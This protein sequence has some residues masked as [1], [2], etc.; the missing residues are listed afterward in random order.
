MK[1]YAT[2][3]WFSKLYLYGKKLVPW[4]NYGYGYQMPTAMTAELF[5]NE[6][7]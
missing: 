6:I 2:F 3:S 5:W 1:Y 4:L 7:K